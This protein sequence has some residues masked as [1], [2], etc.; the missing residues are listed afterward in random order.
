MIKDLK[1]I[2]III[3]HNYII[4]HVCKLKHFKKLELLIFFFF[5]IFD[6][7]IMKIREYFVTYHFTY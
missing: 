7:R 1:Y 6:I 5:Y 4:P 2:I 3:Y